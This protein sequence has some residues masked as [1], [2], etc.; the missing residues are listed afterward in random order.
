M[1]MRSARELETLSEVLDRSASNLPRRG[2]DKI[3][4]RVQAIELM[5]ADS[6]WDRAQHLELIAPSR[7]MSRAEKQLVSRG[8][9]GG[10]G[11]GR[12][13]GKGDGASPASR[14]SSPETFKVEE[15]WTKGRRK[16]S[17]AKGAGELRVRVVGRSGDDAQVD[18]WIF[19]WTGLTARQ[20]LGA[21]P[22]SHFSAVWAIPEVWV[23][24]RVTP[25]FQ[26]ASR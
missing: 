25:R 1:G 11:A 19:R 12:G 13:S 26:Q 5:L 10:P 17:R 18:P 15:L 24:G 21:A 2:A 8:G 23:T 20:V 4:Q 3:A 6:G 16:C 7:L 22:P 14:R 9:P